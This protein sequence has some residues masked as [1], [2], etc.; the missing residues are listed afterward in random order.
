MLGLALT[1]LKELKRRVF[2][3]SVIFEMPD[4]NVSHLF[5]LSVNK[6][7]HHKKSA[8]EFLKRKIEEYHEQTEGYMNNQK[9]SCFAYKGGKCCA[10]EEMI[11]E[12]QS[13]PFFKTDKQY[14]SELKKSMEALAK[15]PTEQQRDISDQYYGGKMPWHNDKVFAMRSRRG[16]SEV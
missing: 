8:K 12:K 7:Q 16:D 13:C 10:L 11:C 2:L 5:S 1:A 15:L 3:T 14:I 9:S 6:V 4:E